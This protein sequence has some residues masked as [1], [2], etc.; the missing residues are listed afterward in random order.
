MLD[1]ALSVFRKVSGVS[2]GF[3]ATI[4]V[5]RITLLV[6]SVASVEAYGK[7]F[8]DIAFFFIAITLFP[9]VFKI[10]VSSV[11]TLSASVGS[12]AVASGGGATATDELMLA[13]MAQMPILGFLVDVLPLS[14]TY[15]AQS[16]FSII[17]GLLCAIAPVMFLSH[18]ISGSL[19][20]LQQFLSTLIILCL[21]P[22][23][24]NVL[25]LLRHELAPT[26]SQTSLGSFCFAIVVQ[27]LQLISPLVCMPLFKSGSLAQGISKAA[28]I[29][30]LVSKR[31]D[32]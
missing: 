28:A 5:A 27:V 16:I 23:L 2:S 31:I 4:F 11:G 10:V 22:V 13:M 6:A 12:Q 32:S 20:G 21:W 15:I 19:V 30:T 14:I 7:L 9:Q 17:I 8:K 25:G 29:K 24:W 18:L 26:I 3:V 1:A